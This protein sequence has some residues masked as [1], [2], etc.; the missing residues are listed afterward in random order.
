MN[1]IK[2]AIYPGS[3]DPITNGHVDIISRAK[4]VFDEITI[5]VI[6][7]PDKTP[8]FELEHRLEL[9]KHLFKN[10][11]HIKVE[12]F[13][14]LLA[15]FAQKRNVYTIIRGLRAVSDF[16]FEFQMALTNRHLNTK[17]DTVFFM[18]DE[19]Y[20]YLSSSLVRQL[21]GLSADISSFVPPDIERSLKDRIHHG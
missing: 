4:K 17:I 1:E 20:S 2:R 6:Q 16:D 3:F 7:N 13:R 9:I 21:A 14:G 18:T 10:D 12:A 5:A 19:K 8:F 11:P 15:D